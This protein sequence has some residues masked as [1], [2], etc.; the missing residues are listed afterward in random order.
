[1]SVN[2][3]PWSL[4]EKVPQVLMCQSAL[5]A[6]LPQ[7]L[8]CLKCPSFLNALSFRVPPLPEYL[9]WFEWPSALSPSIHECIQSVYRVPKLD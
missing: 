5:S 6:Q 2:G 4:L 3:V 1:M 8:G 9:E 7:V